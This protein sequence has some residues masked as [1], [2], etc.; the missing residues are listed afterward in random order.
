MSWQRTPV[1]KALVAAIEAQL[2]ELAVDANVMEH[3]TFTVNPPAIVVGRPSEVRYSTAFFGVDDITL[4]VLCMAG[5]EQDDAVAELIGVVNAAVNA[6]P[7]LGGVVP[8]ADCTGERSW[9]VINISG[10]EYLGAEAIVEI[11]M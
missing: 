5:A 4:P 7:T 8:V 6:D 9:R 1:V 10:A 2:A 11:Q 3:P